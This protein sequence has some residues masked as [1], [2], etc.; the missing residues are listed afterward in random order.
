MNR[1]EQKIKEIL[2]SPFQ[3][4]EIVDIKNKHVDKY[5]RSP[6]FTYS[7]RIVDI[8]GGIATVVK[9]GSSGVNKPIQLSLDKLEKYTYKVG[10]NPFAKDDRVNN[11]NFALSSIL[12]AVGIDG[13]NSE[14]FINGLPVM[15]CNW[16]PYVYTEDG[17]KKYYQRDYVWSLD[18]KRNLIDSIYNNVECGKIVVRLRSYSYVEKQAKNG[19]TDLAFKDLVDG[20]Q[21]MNAIKEF[22]NDEWTDN[23]GY[24]YSELSDEAQQKFMEH[25]LFSYVELP[26]HTTDAA[27]LRQFLKTNIQFVPQSPAHLAEVKKLYEKIK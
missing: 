3:I 19:E 5:T 25:Q 20:K 4:G 22:I 21:R 24:Y 10:F 9:K 23:N 11:V 12:H 6:E 16:N 1:K 13:K 7:Y 14:T 27:V 17:D 2:A 18:F 8:Q 15:E 26:E